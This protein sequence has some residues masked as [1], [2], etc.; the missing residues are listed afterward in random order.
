[1]K[2][3][4]A[5]VKNSI[6][7]FTGQEKLVLPVVEKNEVAPEVHNNGVNASDEWVVIGSGPAMKLHQGPLTKEMIR[8]NHGKY[9]TYVLNETDPL[10]DS[11]I[12]K[13]NAWI[14]GKVAALGWPVALNLEWTDGEKHTATL[15]SDNFPAV[16]FLFSKRKTIVDGHKLVVIS[17]LIKK[18]DRIQRPATFWPGNADGIDTRVFTEEQERKLSGEGIRMLKAK[19]EELFPHQFV[20]REGPLV[21]KISFLMNWDDVQHYRKKEDGEFI[22]LHKA[23][24]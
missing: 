16:N 15:V 1:M 17:V 23:V 7:D 13:W 5:E 10:A 19:F 20:N 14:G 21:N 2:S 11:F 8:T 22:V 3:V 24:N 9:V 18:L 12:G 6:F 4:L